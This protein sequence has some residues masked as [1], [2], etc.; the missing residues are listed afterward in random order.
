M[1]KN[2]INY[3]DYAKGLAILCVLLG[4][5]E[6]S[7]VIK[8]S[9][10]SFHMPLF[11]ILSGY[12]LKRQEINKSVIVKN[13]KALMIPY[14]VIGGGMCL[15]QLFTN[16][17]AFTK[18]GTSSLASLLLVGCRINGEEI[19]CFVGAIWFLWVL[20]LSKIYTQYMLKWKYG[21]GIICIVAIFSMFFTKL[22]HIVPPLGILQSLTVSVFLLMGFMFKEKNI[23]NKHIKTVV[24]CFMFVIAIV[25]MT[26]TA[27][28]LRVN[29]LPF[30]IFSC[31][32]SSYISYVIIKGLWMFD[33]ITLPGTKQIKSFLAFCGK[34]SLAFLC[35]H[36]IEIHYHWLSLDKNL[37]V[38]E[39]I[40]RTCY[41]LLIIR[42]FSY[43]PLTKKI[44]RIQ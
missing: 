31:V 17:E 9:I 8:H 25:L 30:N 34:N 32:I 43:F 26:R 41:I 39:F 36:D 28:A 4:H 3:I 29:N 24:Y 37:I 38:L 21:G 19:I 13:F 27:V 20:F 33:Q 5:M 23:F 14:F 16:Y 1:E 18:L 11:F 44:F 22:T 6:I 7:P 12:F 2:R 10:Y 15:W 42:V 40:L 35:V